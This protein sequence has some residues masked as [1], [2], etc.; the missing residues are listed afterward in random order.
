MQ[1]LPRAYELAGV[2]P[3]QRFVY[4][5]CPKAYRGMTVEV[6]LP[7]TMTVLTRPDF[8]SR[9]RPQAHTVNANAYIYYT[10]S[11]EPVVY[12]VGPIRFNGLF[13]PVG[14]NDTAE[15][16]LEICPN[17][18]GRLHWVTLVLKCAS[19]GKHIG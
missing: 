4:V 13:M 6:V 11:K 12:F 16:R 18:G 19:C 7:R 14:R 2:K 3:G 1:S 15:A 17:C 5:E 9:L 10:R 8:G